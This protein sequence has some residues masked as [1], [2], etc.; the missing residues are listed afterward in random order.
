[1]F[2]R[3]LERRVKALERHLEDLDV[4][5]RDVNNNM[6]LQSQIWRLVG[7]MARLLD[8]LGVQRVETHEVRFAKKGTR[9]GK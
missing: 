3:K 7:D 4:A 9:N 2:N 5:T 1:M 6:S 8:Y